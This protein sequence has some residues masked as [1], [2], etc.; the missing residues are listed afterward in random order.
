MTLHNLEH[1]EKTLFQ[2]GFS[3]LV[4]LHVD[5]LLN[6]LH[7]FFFNHSH[8]MWLSDH[9]PVQLLQ[10]TNQDTPLYTQLSAASFFCDHALLKK[11]L[12][13]QQHHCHKTLLLLKFRDV[14]QY[15]N[16]VWLRDSK[17][18]IIMLLPTKKTCLFLKVLL[19]LCFIFSY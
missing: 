14:F 2:N 17:S 6:C 8:V 18:Q 16:F 5:I 10:W 1:L 7:I 9:E 13:I 15:L 12:F 11:Q 19:V 4:L 3:Q